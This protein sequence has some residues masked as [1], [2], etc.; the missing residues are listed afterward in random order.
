MTVIQQCLF[1]KTLESSGS[2]VMEPHGTR[3]N[4][5]LQTPL[6][7]PLGKKNMPFSS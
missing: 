3:L 4:V 5:Y 7:H 6:K 2:P 1:H